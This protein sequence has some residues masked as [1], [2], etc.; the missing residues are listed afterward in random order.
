MA[1][2]EITITGRFPVARQEYSEGATYYK[3]NIVTYGGSAFQCTADGTTAAPAVIDED[4]GMKLN[5]GWIVFAT[6]VVNPITP[7]ELESILK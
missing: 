4:G 1:K 7:A 6:A 5:A 3:D 2:K